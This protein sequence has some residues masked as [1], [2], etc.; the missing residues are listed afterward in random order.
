MG[1]P[2][3]PD[4]MKHVHLIRVLHLPLRP[5]T[6]QSQRRSHRRVQPTR[7]PRSLHACSSRG[8]LGHIRPRIG[9]RHHH[10]SPSALLPPS[11]APPGFVRRR[12]R[13]ATRGGSRR[14]GGSEGGLGFSLPGCSEEA[15]RGAGGRYFCVATTQKLARE[16]VLK[17]KYDLAS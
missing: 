9:P 13:E 14:W 10:H 15:T 4:A 1:M 3:A 7:P 17:R 8:P 2:F 16:V 6:Y 5:P 11:S 12:P